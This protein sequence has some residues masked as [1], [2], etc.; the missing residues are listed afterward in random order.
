MSSLTVRERLQR[1]FKKNQDIDKF[2]TRFNDGEISSKQRILTPHGGACVQAV[3]LNKWPSMD[4]YMSQIDPNWTQCS[5]NDGEFMTRVMDRLEQTRMKARLSYTSKLITLNDNTTIIG[6]YNPIYRTYDV[7]E[8]FA[9]YNLDIKQIMTNPII[10]TFIEHDFNIILIK[11]NVCISVTD[12]DMIDRYYVTPYD[13]MLWVSG[14]LY[15]TMFKAIMMDAN[16]PSLLSKDLMTYHF[17]IND[18]STMIDNCTDVQ[19]ELYNATEVAIKYSN[20]I[21]NPKTIC[22]ITLRENLIR[23]VDNIGAMISGMITSLDDINHLQNLRLDEWGLIEG[24]YRV[25]SWYYV[26][27]K[28]KKQTRPKRNKRR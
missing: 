7:S 20:R 5:T 21:S 14:T 6:R 22:D 8:L 18:T 17:V 24:G 27:T 9:K 12:Y 15:P 3:P 11:Y 23:I 1:K 16:T 26:T 10:R 2:I 19:L 13:G 28:K 4:D 25:P